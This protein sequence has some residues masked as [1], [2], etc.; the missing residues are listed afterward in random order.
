MPH[1]AADEKSQKRRQTKREDRPGLAAA[2]RGFF[3]FFFFGLAAD[4]HVAADHA[5]EI[6][7]RAVNAEIGS[8]GRPSRARPGPAASRLAAGSGRSALQLRAGMKS[9]FAAPCARRPA[10]RFFAARRRS[11][12][13]LSNALRADAFD[14]FAIESLDR[15]HDD[16][17]GGLG[18]EA[19]QTL[20]EIVEA[21]RRKH[22]REVVDC[23]T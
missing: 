21:R 14:V 3:Q 10:E 8:A 2:Q 17:I 16:V 19:V 6:M 5:K 20:F 15:E 9:D 18:I 23:R 1:R 13:R 12:G 7:H 22:A 11:S 4:A